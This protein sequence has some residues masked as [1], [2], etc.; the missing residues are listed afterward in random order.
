MRVSDSPTSGTSDITLA[1]LLR[2][3]FLVPLPREEEI[4]CPIAASD[5]RC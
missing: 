4:E 1:L 2:A 5:L 3:H